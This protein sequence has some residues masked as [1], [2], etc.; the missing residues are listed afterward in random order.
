LS[1]WWLPGEQPR[2][3][4][5]I[6]EF[7]QSKPSG[8]KETSLYELKGIFQSLQLREVSS[9]EDSLSGNSPSTNER[10]LLPRQTSARSA[11]AMSAHSDDAHFD[12]DMM[13][14]HDRNQAMG[15]SPDFDW[16]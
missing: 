5:Q 14:A 10:P 11:T 7:V 15:E 4:K 12:F 16:T 9:P 3:V 13:A 6:R 1:N 8:D 2:L